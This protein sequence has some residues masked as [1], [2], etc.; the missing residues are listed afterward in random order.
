MYRS[1]V[2]ACDRLWFV[3]TGSLEYSRR[4]QLP[5]IWI[6]DLNTDTLIRR[7]D[8]PLDTTGIAS[9]TIDVDPDKCDE[10]YAYLPDW[11]LQTLYV[12]R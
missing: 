7:F 6:F 8:I 1:F 11:I 9:I 4:I 5:S 12:Y 3:D 2:D 10:A